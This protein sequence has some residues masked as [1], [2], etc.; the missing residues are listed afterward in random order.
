MSITRQDFNRLPSNAPPVLRAL[1]E[2]R[3]TIGQ[4][5]ALRPLPENAQKLIDQAVIRVGLDRLTVVADVMAEGLVY[6]LGQQFWGVTQLQWDEISEVGGA[7]RVMEPRSRG[8]NGLTD[9]RPRILPV[10]LTMDDFE[11]GVRTLSA[12]QRA[13]APIDTTL[14]EQ[15]TRRVNE[16]IED[17]AING[18]S[19]NVFGD[20]IPG[21]M[22]AP[23]VN[24]FTY[25]SNLAWDA[26][27]KTGQAIINDVL[28][29]LEMLKTDRKFGPYNLYV[30]T[31]YGTALAKNF[32][33]GVTTFPTTVR[34][35]I[36]EIEAGGRG[37][38]V[39]D[40]DM[41]ATNRT[42]MVQMTS[43]VIDVVDGQQPTVISWE[44]P[45]GFGL[46]W[47]VLACMVPRVKT[48]YTDQSGICVGNV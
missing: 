32:S 36:E 2:G 13:G 1:M 44:D 22:N 46:H 8:E 47:V 9:R 3:I 5:R 48:T 27:S 18:V 16:A 31:S 45:N 17:A 6:P 43:D 7:R 26:P 42:A 10:Y 24:S 21:I 23:N 37:I 14:V 39:R 34:R 28:G 12:S 30:N 15:K 40:A 41:L 20:D 38:R 29:M 35:R 19:A 25:G 4:L 33:D 11:L